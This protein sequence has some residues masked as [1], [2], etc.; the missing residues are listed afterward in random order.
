MNTFVPSA[1]S[2]G[3]LLSFAPLNAGEP[4]GLHEVDFTASGAYANPY[5]EL[6]AQA[7][8]VSPRGEARQI[9]LF[10]DGGSTWKLRVSPEFAGRWKWT[11]QSGDPGLNGRS[12]EFEVTGQ[13]RRGSIQPLTNSPYHFQYQNGERMWFMGDTAWALFTDNAREK[14]DRAAVEEY[15]TTRAEQ[16]FNVVHTM[17]LSE[18]GWGNSGG[19]PFEDIA[20]E[21]LNPGYWQEV[22]RRMAAA[23]SHG[24]IVGLALAWGDKGRQEPFAWS[25]FQGVEARKRYAHYIGARY[26]AFDVYF[27]V[28]GEWH[29]EIGSRD[30]QMAAIRNEFIAIGDV[31]ARAD[32]HN[33]MI[34]IHPMNGDGSVRE[35]NR[36]AWMGFGDYQQNYDLLHERI[37]QSRRFE[38]PVV[39]SEYGY[40]LR[41]Q[42][43]DGVPDK[44]NS[45]S[46]DVMRHATWD[47]VMAGGY[48]VTGFG[49]TYFGGNRDPGFFDVHATRNRDWERQVALIK[50]VFSTREWWRL[51]PHDELVSCVTPRGHDRIELRQKAPPTIAYWCLAQPGREYVVY[52]RGLREPVSLRL[53]M[54]ARD[55]HLEELDPRTGERIIRDVGVEGG[56]FRYTPGDDRDWVFLLSAISRN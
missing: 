32:I 50:A 54:P 1:L 5:R 3:I 21:R 51:E 15:F 39:N 24:F 47:I 18:A 11:I 9:P 34:G 13:P 25:R 12:G 45:T 16:G 22:D 49:T 41:D 19:L 30:A 42:S 23:N 28:S 10:W 20:R 48:F 7:R 37:L 6:Q 36:A 40:Y 27:L 26:G 8:L 2:V 44:D 38:K 17:L 46:L 14:H 35:F 53:E 4:F 56:E 52:G 29:A 33:R 43:G 31:L 55:W